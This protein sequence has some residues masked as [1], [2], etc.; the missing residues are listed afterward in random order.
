MNFYGEV[1]PVPTRPEPWW[2]GPARSLG[3]LAEQALSSAGGITYWALGQDE[4][5]PHE[6]GL[7]GRL[8][9]GIA[10]V[11]AMGRAVPAVARLYMPLV[12]QVLGPRASPVAATA[13]AAAVLSTAATGLARSLGDWLDTF[14][15]DLPR[16]ERRGVVTAV[17]ESLPWL[18]RVP[19]F[20][21]AVARLRTQ[22][23]LGRGAARMV[24][25]FVGSEAP[26]AGRPP[27]QPL[28]RSAQQPDRYAE[29]LETWLRR[30][31]EGRAAEGWEAWLRRQ[32]GRTTPTRPPSP[33]ELAAEEAWLRRPLRQPQPQPQVQMGPPPPFTEEQL[34]V[35]APRPQVV[36]QAVR[37]EEAVRAFTPRTIAGAHAHMERLISERVLARSSGTEP[38]RELAMRAANDPEIANWFR[39]IYG[40]D[41]KSDLGLARLVAIIQDYSRHEFRQLMRR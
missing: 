40:I 30:R 23:R 17:L 25:F 3:T 12:S 20:R 21:E 34:A 7:L 24:E 10:G 33:E 11:A 22:G 2:A 14:A 37:P 29:A 8:G 1:I 4:G 32:T 28:R 6:V 9:S 15:P 27:Q 41:P 5:G 18:G 13:F 16:E 31:E 26:T 39:R 19:W 38:Y 35:L 36:S